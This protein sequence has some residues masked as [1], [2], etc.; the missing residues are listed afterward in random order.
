MK[1]TTKFLLDIFKRE[2]SELNKIILVS[3]IGAA[4]T[5]STPYLYGKLFDLAIF[6]G[7]GINILASLI[8]L[9]LFLSL[10]SNYIS[11]LT[12]YM[13]EVI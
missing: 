4:L 8:G 7:T 2:K 11:N 13:G 6:P 10:L 1:P 5:V 12:G 3:T 9:W